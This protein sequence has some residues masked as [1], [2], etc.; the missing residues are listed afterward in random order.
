MAAFLHSTLTAYRGGRGPLARSDFII[1]GKLAK[2]PAAAARHSVADAALLTSVR[3][4]ANRVKATLGILDGFIE[5]SG[6]RNFL[7]ET[8]DLADQCVDALHHPTFPDVLSPAWTMVLSPTKPERRSIKDLP[9][10]W[11]NRFGATLELL[12]AAPQTADLI[13]KREAASQAAGAYAEKLRRL[14]DVAYGV[15]G[16]AFEEHVLEQVRAEMFEY[17]RRIVNPGAKGWRQLFQQAYTPEFAKDVI[18]AA[19]ETMAVGIMGEAAPQPPRAPVPAGVT[20][21][22]R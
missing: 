21:D 3:E 9:L 15:Y 13:A 5:S 8:A 19:A 17:G 4:A 12:N 14:A 10:A 6:G 22:I 20:V 2:P 7:A 11:T 16:A 1:P 18:K